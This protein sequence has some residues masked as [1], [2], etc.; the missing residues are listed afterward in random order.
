MEIFNKVDVIHVV[1]SYEYKI[2]KEKYENKIIRNIPLYIYEKHYHNI[3][4]DFSKRKDLI[5]V[6]GFLHRP[7]IDAIRWF[8]KKI[9]PKILEKFKDMIFHVVGS[10]ITD[11]ITQMN[12]KN[13]K[14]EGYLSDKDLHILYQK[15]R[16]AVV[17]LRFGAGVKGKIIGAA[18]NQIPIVTTSIGGEGLDY[19]IGAFI[20][21]DNEDSIAKVICDLYED[22]IKL[23]KMSESGKLLIDKYFSVNMAKE[24]LMK[25]L[26]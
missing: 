3:E 14:I 24:I 9:Y 26:K 1:G 25:D 23:Q 20:I 4:K 7:N 6:G 16:I 2:L 22:Y 17:P 15:C 11:E 12:S 19:S 13:I 8:S 21:E 5:F 10:N 18:Y